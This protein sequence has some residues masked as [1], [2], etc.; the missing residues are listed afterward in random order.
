MHPLGKSRLAAVCLLCL[1]AIASAQQTQSTDTVTVVPKLVHFAG[2]LHLPVNQPTGPV[3]ATFAIYGEPEG[4]TP[5]WSEDQ[6][7]ELDASG[8]YTVLLGATKN[9]GIPLELFA[10][11][12]P[13]WLQAKF[14]A[15]GEVDLP[16][17]LLVSVPYALKAGDSDTL[18]GRPASAYLLAGSSTSVLPSEA[19]QPAQSTTAVGAKTAA[20]VVPSFTSAGSTDYIA[21][22]T[23]P[24]GDV[25]N[26]VMYQNGSNIGVGTTAGAISMDVRPTATSPFAQLGVAQTVDYMTLFASDTFGPAFYWDPTKALRFGKGGTALYSAT[27][28]VEYMRIQ[29]NGYVG[30]GTQ[31]PAAP[32]EVKGSAQVDGNLT[33]EG[34]G[35]GITFPNGTTQTSATVSGPQGP[36]GS[37]GPQGATGPAGPTGLQGATGAAGPAGPQGPTGSQGPQGPQGATGSQGPVG[38]QGPLGPQGPTGPEGPAGVGI[39]EPGGPSGFNT[40]VGFNALN[41]NTTGSGNTADGASALF[42]NSTGADNTANGVSALYSNTTGYSNTAT[43]YYALYSNT[44]GFVNTATGLYALHFNTTGSANTATGNGA[45]QSNT[46]GNDNT[47]SG[48]SALGANTTG[49][50]NTAGGYDAL[51]VNTTGNDNT[52]IGWGA[53]DSN[54]AGS[55]NIAVGLLAG[56]NIATTSSNIDIGSQGVASDSGAI[57]I[58]TAATQTSAFIAGIYGVTTSVNNAVP[59]MIDSNGNL[60]TISSSRRYKEDIQDMADASSGLLRLRPVT[61]RYKK[62]YNDGSQPIQYGLIAEEVADVY[63]DLVARSADGQI[64]TVKYQVLGPML[65]N[66]VQKQN[67]T[68][69]AQKEQIQAQGQQ[70]RSLEERLARM[71]A[72]LQQ[73]SVSASSR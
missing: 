69:A 8:N 66:E 6:N 40:G 16:R 24:G 34:D 5:L 50:G 45:L 68:I 51:L 35:N 19:A 49:L 32:L 57:R 3:G 39:Q 56:V 43:G 33:L 2:S 28:F 60:G 17:V 36:Q 63:P 67:S 1:A 61:F 15:P 29:P 26:S 9:G 13:R 47:A 59:V 31:T 21:M 30:I 12:E 70:I 37:A 46:G 62:P 52:A 64:E 27:G 14:Y 38:L 55:N 23:D 58:G 73:V 18:G 48:Y 11:G 44:S 7:V 20:A 42:S 65:L 10:A 22:F 25:G 72:A 53:L 4:G 41:P 71:E 54:T